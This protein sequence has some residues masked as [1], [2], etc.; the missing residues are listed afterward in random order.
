MSNSSDTKAKLL[1][2]AGPIF[3]AKGY[4]KATVREICDAAEVNLAAVSYHFGDKLHLY[5]ATVEHARHWIHARTPDR[6]VDEDLPA[7]SRLALMIHTTLT[8]FLG[9]DSETWHLKLLNREILDPTQA[10][11]KLIEQHFGKR[12][13]ELMDLIDELGGPGLPHDELERM[14]FAVM[15]QCFHYVI[16]GKFVGLMTRQSGTGTHY[17]VEELTE[18]ITRFCLAGI[19]HWKS[20]PFP[21]NFPVPPKRET[22]KSTVTSG[23]TIRLATSPNSVSMSQNSEQEI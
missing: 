12:F 22:F 21:E 19:I 2:S 6:V 1:E 16:A 13:Q 4:S 9:A 17:T 15:A 7:E 3:A 20:S 5:I 11:E 10:C 8:R 18:Q 23:H 14:A